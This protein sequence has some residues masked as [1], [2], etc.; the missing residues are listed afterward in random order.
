MAK[1]Q[2][3]TKKCTGTAVRVVQVSGRAVN[4]CSPCSRIAWLSE[5]ANHWQ[6]GIAFDRGP[7]IDGYEWSVDP[8]PA[9]WGRD[10][11]DPRSEEEQVKSRRRRGL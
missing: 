11:N 1:C 9:P 8:V 7:A 5:Y 4:A 2:M 3:Q 6:R 10:E